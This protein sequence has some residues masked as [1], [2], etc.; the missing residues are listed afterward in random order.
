MGRVVFQHNNIFQTSVIFNLL[1]LAGDS[2]NV[3]CI[4]RVYMSTAVPKF[5][6]TS[7]FSHS[8]LFQYYSLAVC[9]LAQGDIAT[10]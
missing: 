5:C 1:G 8:N 7:M 2:E 3:L 10:V 6:S 4:K 9:P